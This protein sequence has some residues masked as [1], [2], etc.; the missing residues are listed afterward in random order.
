[1]DQKPPHTRAQTQSNISEHLLSR[2]G[3]SPEDALLTSPSP[4]TSTDSSTVVGGKRRIHERNYS[5]PLSPDGW[6]RPPPAA[7][8][9][10]S[11]HGRIESNSSPYLASEGRSNFS[12]STINVQKPPLRYGLSHHSHSASAEFLAAHDRFGRSTSQYKKYMQTR[13]QVVEE[14]T[15][16]RKCVLWSFFDF[17][18][19]DPLG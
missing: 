9:P 14:R 18:F 1:M 7:S 2:T 19:K 6:P 4:R 17:L 5:Y 12:S 16:R 10:S 13:S 11:L 8:R 15:Y 3:A